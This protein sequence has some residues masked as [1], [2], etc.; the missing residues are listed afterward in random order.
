[1][2]GL[3]ARRSKDGKMA[4]KLI[5]MSEDYSL[6]LVHR[7]GKVLV[8][9]FLLIIYAPASKDRGHSVLTSSVCLSAQT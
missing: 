4:Y 2:M 6:Q 7:N 5:V 1:M 3:L 8:L 9:P